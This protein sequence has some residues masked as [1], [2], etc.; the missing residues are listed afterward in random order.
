MKIKKENG[1]KMKKEFSKKLLIVDYLIL[2]AL[3]LCAMIFQTVDFTTIICAWIAQ[4]GISSAAYYWKAKSE[5]RVK[6]PIKVIESLPEE[7]REKIDLTQ[8]ITSIIQS[9]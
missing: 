1:D 5:N 6:I 4:V 2:V 8:V 3:F 7:T 9:E